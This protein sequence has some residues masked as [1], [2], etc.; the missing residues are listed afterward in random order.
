MTTE[1]A[2][3]ITDNDVSELPLAEARADLLRELLATTNA[4]SEPVRRPRRWAAALAAAAAVVAV[5]VPVGLH[6]LGGDES[7]TATD[8]GTA[9]PPPSPPAAPAAFQVRLVGLTSTEPRRD[10]PEWQEL[11]SFACPS[12]PTAAP[13]VKAELACDAQGIKYLLGNAAVEGGVV[14]AQAMQPEGTGGWVV[15]LQLDEEATSELR[16]LTKELA[17]STSQIA[18]VLD[19]EVLSAPTIVGTIDGGQLQLAGDF[20]KAEATELAARLTE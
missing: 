14:D 6:Q 17:G 8:P 1:L 7:G 3:T 18:L 4:A 12:N 11:A 2:P 16:D 9:S 19:G 13:A 15:A 20:T 5:A 10:D